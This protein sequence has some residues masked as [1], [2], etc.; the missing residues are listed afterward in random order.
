MSETHAPFWIYG[1]G[2]LRMSVAP[3]SS[4]RSFTVDGKPQ[5]GPVLRLGRRDWHVVTVEVPRLM[6][7]GDRRVGLLLRALVLG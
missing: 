7:Q 4:P 3:S 5:R 6:R 1:G 2:S